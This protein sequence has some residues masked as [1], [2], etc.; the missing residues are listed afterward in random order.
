MGWRNSTVVMVSE[1]AR[2]LAGN[3]GDGSDHIWAGN[4]FIAAGEVDGK[5]ILGT[6]F[7]E[8][9]FPMKDYWLLNQEFIS[10]DILGRRYGMVMP[11]GLMLWILR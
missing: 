5:R 6:F 1:F 10:L 2:A 3:P 7:P 4:Y 11:S 8:M 9:H